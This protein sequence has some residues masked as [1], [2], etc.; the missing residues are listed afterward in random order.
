MAQLKSLLVNGTSRFLNTIYATDL[1]VSGTTSFA[2][3]TTTG[4]TVNGAATVTGTLTLTKTTDLSGTANN[5]PALVIGGAA[6]AAHI[7]IDA[8]EIQGKATGT[9]T[10]EIYLNNDGGK[11]N[12]SNSGKVYAN[13]GTFRTQTLEVNGTTYY[14]NSSGNINANGITASTSTLGNATITTGV[15]TDLYVSNELRSAKH[16]IE[17]I[18]HL[19][20]VF[21]V[22]PSIEL[23]SGN[24]VSIT[25]ISG[26]TIS[27]IIND[28]SITTTA[29]SPT[30]WKANS[31]I[32][33]AGSIAGIPIGTCSGTI[34]ADLTANKLQI[35]FTY[36]NQTKK[37]LATGNNQASN[38]LS[39]TLTTI[40]GT[41]PIGIY[42]SALGDS[43]W[44]DQTALN[45]TAI[46]IY[47]G[48][49]DGAVPNNTTPV[50]RIGNLAGLP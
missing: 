17:T 41:K 2:G 25:A 8:N 11:V 15:A 14:F 39:I 1:N 34:Q 29:F 49:T 27:A 32:K 20:G 12:L 38:G 13:N 37:A 48:T 10:G 46:S 5:S 24:N 6:T 44:V 28:S 47:G 22:A 42:M 30:W 50:V 7:E 40:G 18:S 9:T 43:T 33:I 16:T 36:P 23:P 35:N 4:L 26:N 3:V 31:I 45:K 19:G 21:Y